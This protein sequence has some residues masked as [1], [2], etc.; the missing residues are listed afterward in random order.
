MDDAIFQAV[1][2]YFLHGRAAFPEPGEVEFTLTLTDGRTCVASASGEPD[3]V[4]I[5]HGQAEAD[6]WEAAHAMLIEDGTI[7]PPG[8]DPE[9]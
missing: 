2:P 5:T 1:K 6:A 8:D 9:S 4:H 3:R 7:E